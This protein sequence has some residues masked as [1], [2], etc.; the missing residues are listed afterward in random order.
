MPLRRIERQR[1]REPPRV[2][3]SKGERHELRRR[4]GEPLAL[5]DERTGEVINAE[6][7]ST[8][9]ALPMAEVRRRFREWPGELRGYL[10]VVPE[11]RW[12]KHAEN[13]QFFLDETTGVATDSEVVFDFELSGRAPIHAV[14]AWTDTAAAP[15]AAVAI[16][17]DLDLELES[18]DGN[19]YR[20]NQFYNGWSWVNPQGWDSRN[21]AEIC[22]VPHPL[23]GHWRARVF[24]RNVYA[25]RQPFAVAVR[26]GIAGMVPAVTESESDLTARASPRSSF[27]LPLR[28]GCR[29]SVFAIDGRQVYTGTVTS[30][31]LSPRLS[32]AP[33]VYLYRLTSGPMPP[34]KCE[35]S[36]SSVRN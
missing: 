8:W 3:G 1:E 18:P 28:L 10:T 31:G 12:V 25:A 6:I 34:K 5:G 11:T 19:H 24:G 29:A 21:T 30:S 32:L 22:L 14:L 26:G 13:L 9:R 27:E 33:G 16:V 2:L 4:P 36:D 20:G 23:A 15:S 35:S 7:Q 17:N